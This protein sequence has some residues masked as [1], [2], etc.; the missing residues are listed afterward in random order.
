MN[1]HMLS[2]ASSSEPKWICKTLLWIVIASD[3]GVEA[4]YSHSPP[5]LLLEDSWISHEL[6]SAELL[7]D[8]M[9]RE[10]LKRKMDSRIM[11]RW[12]LP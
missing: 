7:P 8:G 12:S 10:F 4:G 2:L 3:I 1:T 6:S 9:D 11:G 5:Q